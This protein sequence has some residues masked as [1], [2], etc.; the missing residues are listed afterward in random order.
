[1]SPLLN[2]T[3]LLLLISLPVHVLAY[4][5]PLVSCET[6]FAIFNRIFFISILLQMVDSLHLQAYSDAVPLVL[7]RR[8]APMVIVSSLGQIWFLVLY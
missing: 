3:Y 8:K 4:F 2:Q 1:M 6:H 5:C 7:M